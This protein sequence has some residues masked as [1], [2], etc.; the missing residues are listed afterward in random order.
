M[1]AKQSASAIFA[2]GHKQEMHIAD[3]FLQFICLLVA[4]IHCFAKT[5]VAS[6]QRHASEYD[7][8]SCQRVCL[9]RKASQSLIIGDLYKKAETESVTIN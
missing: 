7:L 9:L 4:N 5:P 2:S 3:N 6:L 8:R 1:F